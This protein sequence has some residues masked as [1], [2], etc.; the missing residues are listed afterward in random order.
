M[1]T[2]GFKHA[3][4]D[5][6]RSLSAKDVWSFQC[7]QRRKIFVHEDRSPVKEDVADV[8]AKMPKEVCGT[9]TANA[10]KVRQFSE[11]LSK[12]HFYPNTTGIGSGSSILPLST[13]T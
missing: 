12:E 13:D 1:T 11:T 9:L 2:K 5:W 6:K 8:Q 4:L 3:S 10:M 7:L